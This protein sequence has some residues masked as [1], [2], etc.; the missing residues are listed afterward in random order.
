M[1]WLVV[2]PQTS[3]LQG[4]WL[5]LRRGHNPFRRLLVLVRRLGGKIGEERGGGEP[6]EECSLMYI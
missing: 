6:L 3:I 1:Q 5:E 2:V 4:G